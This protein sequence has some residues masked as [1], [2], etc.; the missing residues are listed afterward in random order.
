MRNARQKRRMQREVVVPY[1]PTP[2]ERMRVTGCESKCRYATRS[3]ADYHGYQ[4]G[5][6]AYSCGF[7]G[8]WHLTRKRPEEQFEC[9]P[10]VRRMTW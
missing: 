10:G 3:L 1:E 7:C 8:G 2:E 5:L 9:G 6:H 4:Y